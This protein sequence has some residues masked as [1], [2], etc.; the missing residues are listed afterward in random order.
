MRNN[1][2]TT[3]PFNGNAQQ[4]KV[5]SQFRQIIRQLQSQLTVQPN[6]AATGALA[7]VSSVKQQQPMANQDFFSTPY[8]AVTGNDGVSLDQFAL[9]GSRLNNWKQNKQSSQQQPNSMPM[10]DQSDQ[11]TMLNTRSKTGGGGGANWSNSFVDDPL[12]GGGQAMAPGWSDS[13]VQEYTGLNDFGSTTDY[14]YAGLPKPSWS[15]Q[16]GGSRSTGGLTKDDGSFAWSNGSSKYGASHTAAPV[17]ATSVGADAFGFGGGNL[18][19]ANNTWSYNTVQQPP[20]SMYNGGGIKSHSASGAG[21]VGG[22]KASGNWSGNS[23]GQNVGGLGA[24][25]YSSVGNES[26]W[27]GSVLANPSGGASKSRPPP[28]LTQVNHQSGTKPS[29]WMNGSNGEYLRLRNLSSQVS[30]LLQCFV[31]LT[32]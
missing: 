5:I 26:F 14:D 7:A 16:A 6:K 28:G 32:D 22:L 21:N 15:K 20:P 9:S 30:A 17:A 27:N 19:P 12:G 31:Q 13:T 4:C 2:I 18:P 10:M 11:F 1:N 29:M 23:A 8:A 24:D 25:I 3:N